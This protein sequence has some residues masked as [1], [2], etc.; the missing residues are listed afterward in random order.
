MGKLEVQENNAVS[1]S[2]P[3]NNGVDATNYKGQA[4]PSTTKDC[5]LIIDHETGELTLERL[6][7]QVDCLCI[8]LSLVLTACFRFC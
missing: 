7:N 8:I 3:H 4:K 6:S 1:V 2:L 5:V